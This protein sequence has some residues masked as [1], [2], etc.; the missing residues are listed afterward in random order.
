[1][2]YLLIALLVGLAL[3]PLLQV[4]PTRRQRRQAR[5]REAAALAGLFVEFRDLPL[6]PARAASLSGSE[7]QVLY[8]G[9]RL[10]AAAAGRSH[11]GQW[12]RGGG[13][14]FS[15]P[16]PGVAVPACLGALPEQV[17]AFSVDSG[18]C[19]VYWRED[20]DTE[21]VDIIARSLSAWGAQL[22]S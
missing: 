17:L 21:T 4:L 9:L 15:A 22:Q 10:P 1:M 19:G 12:W 11:R 16:R 6:P 13:Q 5:L 2:V 20:G 7:R 3:A 14:W 18:S 8:Y